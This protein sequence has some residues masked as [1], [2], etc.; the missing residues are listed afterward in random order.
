MKSIGQ[1]NDQIYA[2]VGVQIYVI[3]TIKI[4]WYK[5]I[6]SEIL[7]PKSHTSALKPKISSV[8]SRTTGNYW[9]NI[10]TTLRSDHEQVLCCWFY[11]LYLLDV[12]N[13]LWCYSKINIQLV[14]VCCIGSEY[15]TWTIIV[16][17]ATDLVGWLGSIG[18]IY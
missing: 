4:I 8:W 14:V 15:Y 6:T 16:R 13:Y 7:T 9:F 10:L 2:N 3:N 5:S 1:I 18:S 17:W 11:W 12:E